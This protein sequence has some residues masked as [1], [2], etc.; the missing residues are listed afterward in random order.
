[1]NTEQATSGFVVVNLHFNHRGHEGVR[2]TAGIEN[3]LDQNYRQHLA[4]CYRNTGSDIGLGDR[5]PG[6]G[7]GIGLHLNLRR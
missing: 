3:V 1:M 5:M 6:A 7:R 4:G 2:L